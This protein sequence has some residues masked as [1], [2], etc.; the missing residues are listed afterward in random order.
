MHCGAMSLAGES[1][2]G[3]GD[4][5]MEGRCQL[6]YVVQPVSS[7]LR[8]PRRIIYWHSKFAGVSERGSLDGAADAFSA[9]LDNAALLR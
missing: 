8:G 4:Q 3:Y 6:G 2:A 5:T 9:M 1:D 7:T